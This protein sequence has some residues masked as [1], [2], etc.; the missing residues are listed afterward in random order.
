[1]SDQHQDH[2]QDP[3]TDLDPA[4]RA[5]LEKLGAL[6]AYTPPA[7]L[8]LLLSNRATAQSLGSPPPPP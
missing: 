4:R 2:R 3:D 6:A 8:T 5:A 7:L 1:M